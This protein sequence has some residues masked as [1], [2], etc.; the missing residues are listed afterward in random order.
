MDSI[1]KDMEG[2]GYY[3]DNI[4]IYGGYTEVEQQHRVQKVLQQYVKYR[5]GV[6]LFKSEFHVHDT[7][8]Q[9]YVIHC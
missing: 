6:N 5:L 7:I 8:F 3:C 1:F 2:Y 9:I 4:L